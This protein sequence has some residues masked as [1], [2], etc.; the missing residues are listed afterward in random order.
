MSSIDT[1]VTSI[2]IDLRKL[3]SAILKWK[4]SS[5]RMAK[6]PLD[7]YK[8]HPILVTGGAGAIGS[9]LVQALSQAGANPVI[10]LDDLSSS[11]EWNIPNLSNVLFVKF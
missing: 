3:E 8:N 10:V 2:E 1:I 4:S 11:Y 7:H 6:S 9:N 5:K